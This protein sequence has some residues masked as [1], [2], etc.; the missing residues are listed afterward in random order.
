MASERFINSLGLSLFFVLSGA[1]KILL[2]GCS[3]LNE[4]E[5]TMPPKA[6]L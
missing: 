6:S 3:I 4:K 1:D 5:E 2:R